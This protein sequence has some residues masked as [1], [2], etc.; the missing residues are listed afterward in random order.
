MTDKRRRFWIEFWRSFDQRN[1]CVI[2]YMAA[3]IANNRRLVPITNI[4]RVG[5]NRAKLEI[6]LIVSSLLTCLKYPVLCVDK[7]TSN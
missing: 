2:I 5:A 3:A 1:F 4:L 6:M 7:Q